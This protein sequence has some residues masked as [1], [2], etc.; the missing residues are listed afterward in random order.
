[1]TEPASTTDEV[2]SFD[3]S[4]MELVECA[5]TTPSEDQLFEHSSRILQEYYD[6]DCVAIMKRTVD[7]SQLEVVGGVGIEDDWYGRPLVV[8]GEQT[9]S[10]RAIQTSEPV[11]VEDIEEETRFGPSLV[12]AE[13]ECASGV[14]APIREDDTVWGVIELHWKKRRSFTERLVRRLERLC[15]LIGKA[16][17]RLEHERRYCSVL[18]SVSDAVLVADDDAVIEEANGSL[19]RLTGRTIEELEGCSYVELVVA[20]DRP[21]LANLQADVER[22]GEGTARV[23]LCLGDQQRVTAEVTAHRI[24]GNQLLV[25]RD[26]TPLVHAEHEHSKFYLLVENSSDFIGLSD[27]E[28]RVSYLNPAGHRLVNFGYDHAAGTP[29]DEFLIEEWRDRFWREIVPIVHRDGFWEGRLTLRDFKSDQIHPTDASVLLLRDP[30]TDEPVGF[31]TVQRDLTERHRLRDQLRQSQKMEALGLLAGGVAH[32]FNNHL[33][34]IKGYVEMM[35]AEESAGTE[36]QLRLEKVEDVSARAQR[37]ADQLLTFSRRKVRQPRVIDLCEAVDGMR[38]ML[39]SLIGENIELEYHCQ[40]EP[41]PVRVDPSDVEQLVLNLALNARDAIRGTGALTL[42]VRESGP[43]ELDAM[44]LSTRMRRRLDE[45]VI[46]EVRDTGKGMTREVLERVF[47]P[48]YTTKAPRQGTGLGLATVQRI[49]QEAGGHIEVDSR[50]GWGT[51]FEIVLP[52]CEAV[53]EEDGELEIVPTSLEGD[54]VVMVVEDDRDVLDFIVD[55]LSQHGYDPVPCSD[56][57]EAIQT[58]EEY[59]DS[60]D[61]VVSDVILPHLASEAIRRDLVDRYPDIP[62]VMISGYGD[63]S[64]LKDATLDELPFLPKPMSAERLLGELRRVLDRRQ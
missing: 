35:L 26:L 34:V 39:R 1:M 27:L 7:R 6:S 32:D 59:A 47:E 37:L 2:D 10:D 63:K 57:A 50:P 9:Q 8:E 38:E 20:E 25:W 55:V 28:G 11:V 33:T 52:R 13:H 62:F 23:D 15:A 22:D 51:R 29:V 14:A 54:E 56:G 40:T 61:I 16:L 44:H 60:I 5:L 41:A 12:A 58:L 36:R 31:A 3:D 24:D 42:T 53:R 45:A 64:G 21:K 46:L 18:D 43:G 48:F 49:V 19:A 30:R 4:L 17:E